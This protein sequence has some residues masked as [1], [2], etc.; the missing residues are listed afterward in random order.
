[1]DETT[2]TTIRA[3]L[4]KAMD[5]VCED[6]EALIIIRNGEQF[7]VMLSLEEHRALEET[8]ICCAHQRMQSAYLQ[9]LPN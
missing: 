3:D 4:A 9:P 7:V 2:Y 8:P 5:R 1:M 6:H